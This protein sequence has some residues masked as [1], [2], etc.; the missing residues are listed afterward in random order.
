MK[1]TNIF[2]RLL[3]DNF[4]PVS[5]T[6]AGRGGVSSDKSFGGLIVNK[7]CAKVNLF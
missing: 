5:F 4:L 1:K 2:E 6:T 3:R 7:S